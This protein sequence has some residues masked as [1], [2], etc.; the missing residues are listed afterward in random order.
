MTNSYAETVIA[1][2]DDNPSDLELAAEGLQASGLRSRIDSILGGPEALA[3]LRSV[4]HD[5]VHAPGLVLLDINMPRVVGFDLVTF[6]RSEPALVKTPVFMF[7][8]SIRDR[9]VKQAETLGATGYLTKPAT[10]AEYANVAAFITPH[11]QRSG[12][13]G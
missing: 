1:V 6:I 9:D 10:F 11:L 3:Y 2:T 5:P 7:I 12:S 8:T 4:A 13:A